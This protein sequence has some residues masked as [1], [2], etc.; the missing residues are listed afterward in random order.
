[1]SFLRKTLNLINKISEIFGYLAGALCLTMIA[2]VFYDVMM[3]YLFAS[4]SIGMQELE[5]HLF[6]GMFLLGTAYTLKEDAHVRVDIFY[7]KMNPRE[8]AMVNIIG[9]L[10]FLIPF[11]TMIAFGSIDFV[12][13]SFAINEQS[14]DPGGLP[15]RYV[16]KGI[17]PFS[18][19]LLLVQ[20]VGEVLRN[21]TVTID[22]KT[23]VQ[24]PESGL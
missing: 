12:A 2:I 10:F 4:G 17:I 24:N 20:G 3:R 13:Y 15:V 19:I 23:K 14:P 21:M 6:A 11:C 18:Y 5:W 8:K 16:L 1:M 7:E 9:V 22:K